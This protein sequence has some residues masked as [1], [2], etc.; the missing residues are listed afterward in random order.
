MDESFMKDLE[1][2]LYQWADWYSRGN[3]FGLGYPTTSVEYRIMTEG[4]LART[5]GPKSLP[6]NES[7]EQIEE[8]VKQMAKQ[9]ERMAQALRCHYFMPGSLRNKAAYLQISHSHFKY[10]VDLAH[11]W[12]AGNLNARKQI[13]FTC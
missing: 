6:S 4:I 9:S 10:Y 12:L 8:L 1:E 11:Q 5:N 3:F 7:A 13:K 2:R